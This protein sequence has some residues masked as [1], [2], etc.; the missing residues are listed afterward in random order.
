VGLDIGAETPE[1]IA[2]AVAAEIQAVF[3]GRSGGSL[4]D[5]PG[6]I[7]G[8]V[9]TEASEL[10]HPGPVPTGMHCFR[11]GNAILRS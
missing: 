4:R 7:H 9:E 6:P 11:G 8:R 3:H 2:L 10:S 1:E 5:R